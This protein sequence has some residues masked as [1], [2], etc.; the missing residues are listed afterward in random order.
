VPLSSDAFSSFGV[1]DAACHN[2]EVKRAFK[3]LVSEVIPA[4]VR[5]LID[6]RDPTGYQIDDFRQ[7]LACSQ[8]HVTALLHRKGVNVRFL[9]V[10]WAVLE[11]AQPV[12]P[13]HLSSSEAVVFRREFHQRRT[14]W[15]DILATEMVARC[16]KTLL[17]KEMREATHAD[18]L[19][20]EMAHHH[21][22]IRLLNQLLFEMPRYT[23]SDARKFRQ[24]SQATLTFWS[25]VL[26]PAL[27]RKFVALP[28]KAITRKSLQ[29]ALLY[30]RFTQLTGIRLSGRAID[31]RWIQRGGLLYAVDI[32]A[33]EPR[34]KRLNV[35][36]SVEG[37]SWRL[38]SINQS[39]HLACSFLLKA[40]AK[41]HQVL[42][43]TPGDSQVLWEI[44]FCYQQL[45]SRSKDHKEAAVFLQ[46]AHQY[47]HEGLRVDPRSSRLTALSLANERAL[48]WMHVRKVASQ[49]VDDCWVG[50]YLPVNKL[51]VSG[52]ARLPGPTLRFWSLEKHM[53]TSATTTLPDPE[54]DGL[55]SAKCL[56]RLSTT[57]NSHQLPEDALIS[58]SAVRFRDRTLLAMVSLD[59]T[60]QIWDVD[61]HTRLAVLD[62]SHTWKDAHPRRCVLYVE[63][64]TLTLWCGGRHLSVWTTVEEDSMRS[65]ELRAH[66][67]TGRQ[68]AAALLDP[69]AGQSEGQREDEDDLVYSLS[70]VQFGKQR[71]RYVASA[72]RGGSVRFWCP[73]TLTAVF[74]LQTTHAVRCVESFGCYFAMGSLKVTGCIAIH[75]ADNGSL[76]RTL[77]GHD[78]RVLSLQ[79]VGEYLLSSGIDG[80]VRVWDPETGAC[81]RILQVLKGEVEHFHFDRETARLVVAGAGQV[82]LYHIPN[83]LS[84]GQTSKSQQ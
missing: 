27:G 47:I 40:I 26:I 68:P 51:L 52:H 69:E 48:R 63:K 24:Q 38:R 77:F 20:S 13:S 71:L 70:V 31:E 22:I 75:D 3:R 67:S 58:M 11:R 84:P 46:Y 41:F 23:F 7:L 64:D 79:W 59:Y 56:L 83:F 61:Q 8:Y 49:K 12:V 45:A 37:I 54:T 33:L 62:L 34:V 55:H 19:I 5:E 35:M 16:I 66:L 60:V 43:V 44:A 65:F 18:C 25:D 57:T 39:P 28:E 78:W 10:V 4:F 6:H 17:Q 32:K 74:E 73:R 9:G 2:L 14:A 81:L 53:F 30:V 15:L 21:V 1:L 29:R 72:R 36:E 42:L 76:V 50:Q 80:T 82:A